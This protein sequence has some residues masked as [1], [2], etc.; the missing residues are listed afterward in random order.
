MTTNSTTPI[1]VAIYTRKST[2]EGLEQEFNSLDAQREAALAYIANR[3]HL[4]WDVVPDEYNDGGYTGGN[5]ERPALQRLLRDIRQGKI[6]CVVTYKLDRISRSLMDFAQLM[7]LFEQYDVAFVSITQEFDSSTPVGRLTLN[8]L[9]SFSQFEREIISERTRDK[10]AASRKK[11]M[12]IGGFPPYGY[13]I[14]SQTHRLVVNPTEADIV[15]EL[16]TLFQQTKSVTA[17]MHALNA[18][19]YRTKTFTSRRG[20]VYAG[21][22]W[23]RFYVR[24]VLTNPLYIGKIH[25]RGQ[26]YAGQQ[27]PIISLTQWQQVQALLPVTSDDTPKASTTPRQVA[28]LRGVLRCGH[29]GC[30]ITPSSCRKPNKAYRYYVCSTAQRHGERTCPVRSLPA[31]EL[32][33][34]VVQELR[35][36]FRTPERLT[37][38]LHDRQVDTAGDTRLVYQAVVALQQLDRAWEGLYPA[39]QQRLIRLLI[40]TVT[41][42]V[43]HV[44]I[45]IRA[46]GL[47]ELGQDPLFTQE[48]SRG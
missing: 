16:F 24:R 19:G 17:V 2:E 13:D 1:R 27:E 41:I 36:L 30:A 22:P 42:Y 12:F 46:E 48:V 21:N 32:E 39:V 5:L 47:S 18:K 15:R 20:R 38:A 4:H 40:E 10:M 34:V 11:G 35:T 8:I 29:C 33:A 37:T 43:D 45:C 6:D 25:Y 23:C 31:G 14:D 44:D 28:L 3:R 26:L 7:S 9:S